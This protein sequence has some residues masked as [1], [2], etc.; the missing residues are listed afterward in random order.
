[1]NWDGIKATTGATSGHRGWDR[2]PATIK[3]QRCTAQP[4]SLVVVDIVVL[5]FGRVIFAIYLG[6]GVCWKLTTRPSI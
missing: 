5:L 6:V 1:M 2:K 3:P 4:S